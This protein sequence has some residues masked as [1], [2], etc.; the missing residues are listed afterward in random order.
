MIQT[1]SKIYY[2]W[3][4]AAVAFWGY[5][6]S[7]GTGFYAFNAFLEPLCTARGW[8]RTDLNLALVIGTVFGFSSQYIYG[9]VLMKTGVRILMLAGSA[10]AGI[11]FI[12]IARVQTL[13]EFYLFY[14]LLFIGNGAYG[15]IVAS[16]A[17][18]NW[19]V[20]K[21]GKA[22]GFATAGMS[23]SGAILPIVALLLIQDTG[24]ENAALCIGLVM[25]SFGPL[26]WIIIKDWPEDMGMAPDGLTINT[27]TYTAGQIQIHVPP[28]AAVHTEW[29]LSKLIRT[30]VFWKL[31]LAFGLLMIGTVGVM[32]QLK[33]RFADTGFSHLTAMMMMAATAL[34]G[35]A[36]KYSWGLMCDRF[37]PKR[38]AIAMTIANVLGLSLALV[39]NSTA[40]L[41]IF[42]PVFGF[43]MGGIMSTFPIIV[44]TLFGRKNFASVLRYISI[45]LIL[46]M[47][48][49]IIA[50]QS[51]DI[52]GSYDTAYHI[53]IG[54]DIVAVLLL[55]SLKN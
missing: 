49:Y 53:F 9:T 1:N 12:F 5:F 37:K 46:Q 6:L 21:R 10:T 36:G 16:N 48:G 17:V 15:G 41:I 24:I 23:I 30:D 19:F 27:E 47:F 42:I 44:A 38:V 34:V 20:D 29:N 33:P 3:Y 51:F 55:C 39:K 26:A 4:I 28:S 45:F 40:A 2:G 22:I 54:L 35:A 50:G 52:T 14:S 11:S 43:S 18:N 8:T 31:G 13:W 32:S 25:V 7:V